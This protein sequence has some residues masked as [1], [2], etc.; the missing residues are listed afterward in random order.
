M[1]IASVQSNTPVVGKTTLEFTI[2]FDEAHG[3]Y[4]NRSLMEGALNELNNLIPENN[5][6]EIE[7]QLL[8]QQSDF[9]STNLQGIDLLIITNPGLQ[10][11]DIFL[12]SEIEAI[13]DFVELGGS[14]FLLS[15]PLTQKIVL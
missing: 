4:F 12:P 10:E 9:N 3:Q 13:L 15:N 2:L 5:E 11:E 1:T 7:I 14:L 6:T 8:F